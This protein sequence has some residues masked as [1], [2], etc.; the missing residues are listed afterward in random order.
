MS[1]IRKMTKED[2]EFCGELHI[3]AFYGRIDKF[4]E[5]NH[6]D[7]AVK[8]REAYRFSDYFSSFIDDTDKYAY[9]FIYEDKVVGYLTALEIPAIMGDKPIFIDSLAV[10]PEYQQKGIGTS[11]LKE[12]IGMFPES[13][14][15][16]LLTEKKRPAYEFYKKIGFQDIDLRVMESSQIADLIVKLEKK[17]K[18]LDEEISKL[19]KEISEKK[20]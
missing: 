11:C 19:T 6:S 14:S 17:N 5:E 7:V 8:M 9:C 13:C 12:F 10:D 18:E 4:L 2:I 1:T 20:L 16:R 3:K 15:K